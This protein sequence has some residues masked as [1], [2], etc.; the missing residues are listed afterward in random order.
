MDV[1]ERCKV[2]HRRYKLLQL[3]NPD[4]FLGTRKVGKCI[5]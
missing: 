3:I 5:R 2:M 1:A 4:D